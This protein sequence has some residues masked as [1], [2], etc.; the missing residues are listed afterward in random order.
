MI[1]TPSALVKQI[2]KCS[3]WIMQ[4][5][6]F[7]VEVKFLRGVKISGSEKCVV[8]ED[9][10]CIIRKHL[11]MLKLTFVG[12]RCTCVITIPGFYQPVRDI[13]DLHV[14]IMQTCWASC[15]VLRDA[16]YL[17]SLDIYL[18]SRCFALQCKLQSCNLKLWKKVTFA[19]SKYIAFW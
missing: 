17:T 3:V 8:W 4:C 16:N 10:F 19:F 13:V 9:Q 12:L 6:T 14:C 11:I 7:L 15:L 2:I 18:Y 5:L 1:L